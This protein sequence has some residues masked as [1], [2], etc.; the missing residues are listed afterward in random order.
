MRTLDITAE[1]W[2]ARARTAEAAR[3]AAAVE[4][5]AGPEG[6]SSDA[7]VET[8]LPLAELAVGLVLAHRARWQAVAALAPAVGRPRPYLI[9]LT[10]GVAAGKTV[11]AEVLVALLD[12]LGH[13]TAVVSTDGFLLPNAELERRGLSA[14]KGFPESYDHPALVTTIA[15]LA[16]AGRDP[17]VPVTVPVY[18]HGAYDVTGARAE[19][20]PGVDIVIVE[21]VNVLQPA[22]RSGATGGDV[23][24]HLDLSVYLD[25]DGDDIRAWFLQRLRRLRAE[26]ADD[27]ASFYAGFAGMS[28]AEFAAMGEAVWAGVNE[29]NLADHIAPSRD[30]ADVVVDKAAD[31]TVRRV[32]LRLA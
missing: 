21:G 24:D 23:A 18:D 5:V 13:R 19:V 11:T 12:A 17:A 29:P 27:P 1:Q 15:R 3:L 9:G 28:D 8:H 4:P 22:P 31:H 6:L 26:T 25:A 20:D 7:L 2:R 30:R 16:D 10:G 14:R 32:R